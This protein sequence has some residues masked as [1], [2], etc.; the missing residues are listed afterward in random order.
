MH[1]LYLRPFANSI[2][3]DVASVMCSYNRLNGS[4]ACQNSYFPNGILKTELGFQGYVM[5]DWLAT[6]A[7]YDAINA[8]LDMDMPD[9]DF[10]PIDG[11]S[12]T[13]N[14]LYSEPVYQ[15]NYGPADV[16]VRQN[17]RQH[18][19]E[20]G[21]AGTVLLKNVDSTLPLRA[22]RSIGVFGND[23]GDVTD[24]MYFSGAAIGPYGF[25]SGTLPAG[26]GSGTGRFSY[27]VSPLE[28]I[29]ARAAQ[30]NTLVQYITKNTV[31]LLPLVGGIPG[32]TFANGL[33]TITPTPDACLVFLKTWAGQGADRTSLLADWNSTA[34]VEAV[35]GYC[36]NTVVITHST[37]LN[38]M[39]WA[40][41]PNVT[42][43][44][45]AH[46]PGEQ[47]GNSIVDML[48]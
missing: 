44:I 21:A 7:G 47:F 18:I 26:G 32:I 28:V 25:E 15:F 43:I 37:G 13:L 17:H 35:A 41:H 3:A 9:Q 20:L 39:P 12:S 31:L 34:V 6:H 10:P 4:Y 27:L 11:Q 22:P 30:D 29:K 46:L 24:G 38:I 19:R 2:R 33:G 1:E 48:Y 23:A 14:V 42:A 16:D 5:S 36:N 45:N 8:G 40:D